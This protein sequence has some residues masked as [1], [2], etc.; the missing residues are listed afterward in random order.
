MYEVV[1]QCYALLKKFEENE[2]NTAAKAIAEQGIEIDSVLGGLISRR[3]FYVIVL[4]FTVFFTGFGVVFMKNKQR[5]LFVQTQKLTN[6]A[7]NMQTTWG[8]LLLEQSTFAMQARIERI[9]TDK[10]NMQMPAAKNI[11]MVKE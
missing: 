2:M 1:A 6:Q 9:A 4:A 7:N 5:E 8:R 3:H 11:I 10:L